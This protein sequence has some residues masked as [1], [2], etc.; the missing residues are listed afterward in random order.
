MTRRVALTVLAAICLAAPL[1]AQTT[2]QQPTDLVIT[3][4]TVITVDA[5]RRVLA[6]GAVAIRGSDIVAVGTPGD[7]AA[8]YTAA[9]A[10]DATGRVVMPGLVNTH[11]HAPMVLYRGLA[12]D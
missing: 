4:G 3:G 8:A 2:G 10:L 1:G 6:P 5:S 7:I 11:G 9:R 12:D